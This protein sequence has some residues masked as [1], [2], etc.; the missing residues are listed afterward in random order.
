MRVVYFI[1]F[2]L[3]SLSFLPVYIC[4]LEGMDGA[5]S[6]E[7]WRFWR[8]LIKRQWHFMNFPLC[9]RPTPTIAYHR[10]QKPP[11]SPPFTRPFVLFSLFVCLPRTT[12]WRPV[13]L[14]DSRTPRPGLSKLQMNWHCLCV[15]R[16]FVWV[17]VLRGFQGVFG[18]TPTVCTSGAQRRVSVCLLISDFIY[19]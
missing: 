7:S 16:L 10:P 4:V 14:Q 15:R 5:A 1:D 17:C 3:K 2:N 9:S 18:G 19:N 8:V 12:D 11:S 6:G 13:G